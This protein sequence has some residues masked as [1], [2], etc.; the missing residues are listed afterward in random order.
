M[1]GHPV[2]PHLHVQLVGCG[3]KR[4]QVADGAVG[5]VHLLEVGGGV[6]AVDAAA[7]GV[8]GHQPHDVYAQRLQ[9][10]QL[11]LGGGQRALGSKRADVHFVNHL[12]TCFI[13]GG[14][15]VDSVHIVGCQHLQG[16][17]C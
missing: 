13:L 6:G 4:L 14:C 10:V 8:D 9:L 15:R 12:M 5:G 7:P 17:K 3:Y 1:V 11:L 16:Q 2:E